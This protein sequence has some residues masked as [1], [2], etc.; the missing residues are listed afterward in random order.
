MDDD[1]P[2]VLEFCETARF[3]LA[4]HPG[5]RARALLLARALKAH[6]G[7]QGRDVADGALRFK[8]FKSYLWCYIVS[9]TQDAV[10]CTVLTADPLDA[11]DL[12]N[13]LSRTV[14]VGVQELNPFA[15]A[16]G[17]MAEEWKRSS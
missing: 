11:P 16:V 17:A 3:R 6:P 9:R 15:K 14:W 8:P 10:R 2:F 5:L 7:Q 12:E 1:I 13:R 4:E